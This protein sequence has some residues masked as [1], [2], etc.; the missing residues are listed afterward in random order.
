[1]KFDSLETHIIFRIILLILILF[2]FVY[3]VESS[4]YF[5]SCAFLMV[6][7]YQTFDL[8]KY[9]N[10]SY[11]EL[12]QFIL[13]IKYRDFSQHFNEKDLSAK[14]LR[15]AFNQ[16]NKTF[17][18]LEFE[19]ESQYQYLIKILEI[20]NTGILSYNSSGE[21][22]WMNARLKKILSTPYLKS[23]QSLKKRN[24]KLYE[25]IITLKPGE[26]RLINFKEN[27]NHKILL[28][29]TQ[30]NI[31]DERFTIIAF[32]NVNQAIDET[33]SKA[34]HKLLGVLNHEIMN[35]VSPIASLSETLF[36]KING[37]ERLMEDE[38]SKELRDGI[39]VI[40]NRSENL[41]KFSETYR[42][43]YKDTQLNLALIS[44]RNIF[45]NLEIL[46]EQKFEQENIKLLI[47]IKEH[48]YKINA[49]AGLLEQVL[50]N[51]IFNA[52][53]AF[54]NHEGQKIIKL[55][56]YPNDANKI[57][58]EVADNGEGI[59]SEILENIFIPFF[60]TKKKGSGIGLSL[61]KQI[62]QMHH[63]QLSVFSELGKGS[64]FK[65]QF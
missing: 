33:E 15:K 4:L 27:E 44:I 10:K 24:D 14:E 47:Q 46:L 22:K 57:I 36:K 42:H 58:I 16:I 28:S 63:G 25:E 40:K 20:V 54:N 56:A 2:G 8:I 34:W 49:D 6:S 19:R 35:S 29:C 11:R 61:S 23:I 50:L 31:D 37:V 59:P 43:L 7:A 9:I 13:S 32:Q 64:V 51:L 38:F 48:D 55:S 53:D 45:E 1:M 52:I 18:E 5:V 26:T 65:L 41:L 60:T 3:F 12:A 39:N 62:M 17:K 30:F 21:I